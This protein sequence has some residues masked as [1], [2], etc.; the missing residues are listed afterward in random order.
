M[1]AKTLFLLPL[2]AISALPLTS[3][4]TATGQG[5]GFGA[6]AGH[7]TTTLTADG[8]SIHVGDSTIVLHGV[9]ALHPYDLILL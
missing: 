7:V 8:L 2:L 3:C 5:A 6:A 1:K 4:E 9:V